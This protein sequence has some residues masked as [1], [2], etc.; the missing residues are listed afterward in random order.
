[1]T[2]GDV[3]TKLEQNYNKHYENVKTLFYSDK[4]KAVKYIQEQTGC[5]QKVAA[6]IVVEWMNRKPV[7]YNS[8]SKS[9]E[10]AESMQK[11]IHQIASDIRFM[12]NLIII[13]LIL[14]IIIGVLSGLGFA[15]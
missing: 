12:K 8:Q 4:M 11:D 14:S 1:M 5:D 6:Q 7:T 10:A 2:V 15:I 9:N 3:R 13:G